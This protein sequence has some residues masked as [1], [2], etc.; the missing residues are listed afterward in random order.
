M[1]S[2]IPVDN[3]YGPPTGAPP[4]DYQYET[5][6][7]VYRFGRMRINQQM[8][9]LRGIGP[10]SVA[11]TPDY[12]SSLGGRLKGWG[13][14][15]AAKSVAQSNYSKQLSMLQRNLKFLEERYQYQFPITDIV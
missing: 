2:I 15:N 6:E 5:P 7:D 13:N 3:G 12:I 9:Q 8:T 14:Y 11:K 10:Q 4:D 1:T